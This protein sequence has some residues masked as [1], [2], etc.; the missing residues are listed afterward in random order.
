MIRNNH[1]YNLNEQRSYPVD[2]TASSRDSN[3][4][5]LPFGFLADLNLR[6]P[7]QYG[8]YAYISAA[9]VTATSVSIM[10]SSC[11]TLDN[12][13]ND[14]TLLAGLTTTR[15][16]SRSYTLFPLQTFQPFVQGH[17]VFG[18]NLGPS[19]SVQLLSP[20][21]S[22]L[23]ARAARAMPMSLEYF[24]VSDGRQSTSGLVEL[25]ARSPLNIRKQPQ[26]INGKPQE[27]VLVLEMIDTRV[28]S[29]EQS[30]FEQYAG[31][32]AA[33]VNSRNCGDPQ[34]IQTIN[35]IGPDCQGAVTLNFLGC[36]LVARNTVDCGVV[37]DC[38][39]SLDQSCAP[40]FLPALADGKLPSE[41]DPIV[42]PPPPPP[43]PP[44]PPEP[45]DVP[46]L[47]PGLD[48]PYCD[49]FDEEAA[50]GFE[51]QP[52]SMFSFIADD[53]PAE[54]ICCAGAVTTIGCD[55]LDPVE[56]EPINPEISYGTGVLDARTVQHISLF[57][58]DTQVL[59]R[60]FTSDVRIVPNVPG[61]AE[62]AGILLNYRL[63]GNGL[64]RFYV[65]AVD[66]VNFKFGIYLF[67]GI[68]LVPIIE[69]A[70]FNIR[71]GEWMRITFTATEGDSSVFIDLAATLTGITRPALNITTNTAI[72]TTQWGNDEGV[73]GVL[74]DRSLAYFSYW[75]I[76]AV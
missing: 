63:G 38:D 3:E 50:V 34:P 56:L 62:I 61:A 43:D 6:W 23:T 40:K 8:R 42:V 1:W 53:S 22:L 19:F 41:V 5:Q 14:S 70:D 9:S 30:V 26:V 25:Q 71:S 76:D 4:T 75:R 72:S 2:E 12:S 18:S 44:E 65:A 28:S 45:P 52:G 36:A 35:G 64:P 57:A 66:S 51:P 27:N 10:I 73:S 49:T 46:P 60:Q 13:A 17:I 54:D 47:V 58:A 69:V 31:A 24:G 33:R 74:I 48:L 7:L 68:S 21:A 59:Y 39:L 67:N 11:S 15:T 29:A 20:Q 16:A 37:L 55:M 32:C